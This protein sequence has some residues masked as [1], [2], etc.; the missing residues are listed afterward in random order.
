MLKKIVNKY[1]L[2]ILIVLLILLF[3]IFL[4]YYFKPHT[5]ELEY[6]IEDVLVKETYSKDDNYYLFSF[7]YE[8]ITYHVISF[9]KYTNQRNLVTDIDISTTDS[10]TCLTFTS[11]INL[12]P[13]CS[14][15]NTF[16]SYYLDET[17]TFEEESTYQNIAINDLN[18]KTYLLWNY[19]EFIYLSEDNNTTIDLFTSDIYNLSLTYSLD[20]YLLVP[21]YNQDYTFD[22]IYLINASNAK[23]STID[24]RFA[25][26]FD[27]YFLGNDEENVYIYDTKNE[28]EYYIDTKKKEIYKT[29][30]KILTDGTWESVTNQKLKN[31]KLTFS[32]SEPFTYSLEDNKLYGQISG[33]EKM[34]VSNRS[35][36]KI[37]STDNLDVYYLSGDTLYYFNPQVGEKALLKYSEWEFNYSNMIYIF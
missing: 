32:E 30:Y 4:V 3:I 37:I 28:Q 26:Y 1:K 11:T 35:V 10:S 17:A 13:I 15:D 29:S 12:Y 6:E 25:L 27:S 19:N 36:N 2:I 14:S 5:Y 16:Y 33:Q 18:N 23:V 21:D 34:L 9:D 31:N 8:D 22:S 20:N 24:L 7:E